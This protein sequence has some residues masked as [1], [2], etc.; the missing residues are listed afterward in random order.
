MS[1][2]LPRRQY[3]VRIRCRDCTGEDP[4]G[5]FS[6]G[7]GWVEIRD[8]PI[9]GATYWVN[10]SGTSASRA[11]IFSEVASAEDAREEVESDIDWAGPWTAE[12]VDLE[13]SVIPDSR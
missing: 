11:S 2:R 5:C 13:G 9:S 8:R 10:D 6:G 7:Y 4:A 3:R 1:D 12:V